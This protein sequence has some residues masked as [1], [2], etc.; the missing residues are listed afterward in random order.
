M[1]DTGE[2]EVG[3]AARESGFE[4][5]GAV[6]VGEG[7]TVIVTVEASNSVL[8][9]S[10]EA[11]APFELVSTVGTEFDDTPSERESATR[12]RAELDWNDS[13][14]SEVAAGEG[15]GVDRATK[16]EAGDPSMREG[17]SAAIGAKEGML[18]VVKFSTTAGAVLEGE[19]GRGTSSEVDGLD[20]SMG[21]A[22]C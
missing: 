20:D 13:R 15:M 19:I 7:R 17:V 3:N 4:I 6:V 12:A 8:G 14:S 9:A 1:V 18:V 5:G 10:D 16:S 21:S 11:A 22:D 2:A